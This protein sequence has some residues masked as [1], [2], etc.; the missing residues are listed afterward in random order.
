MDDGIVAFI[1][2]RKPFSKEAY[3]GFR[4]VLVREFSEIWV[5]DLGG[6]VRDNPKLSGTKHNVFG[7][8]TGVAIALCVKKRGG[9]QAVIRYA[10]RPET[11]TKEEKLAF[12]A[13]VTSLKEI[14]F[15]TVKPDSKHNWL[16]QT[17]NDWSE[18]P[19]II[20][21]TTGSTT[22][23]AQERSIFALA[24][25]GVETKRDDWAYDFSREG[26]KSKIEFLIAGYEQKRKRVASKNESPIKWDRE[27]D[28][29]M[30]RD[31]KKRF[32]ST[33][34]RPAA[35]R[36]YSYRFLYYDRHINAFHFQTGAVFPDEQPHP[37]I[38]FTDPFAQ[39]PWMVLATSVIP[40]RHF[41]GAAA[42]AICAGRKR[43]S[44]DGA[45][46][47]N[48]T[49]WAL[50]RF[51]TEYDKNKKPE[52]PITKN[53]IFHY[54]YGVLHDPV[55]REKYALNL[56][57]EFPRIP[58]YADFWKWV[59]WGEK[60]MAL[61]IGYETA[62]PWKLTRVETIDKTAKKSSVVPKTILKAFKEIGTIALDS[63]TQLTGVPKEAWDYSLGSR[64][65]LEWILDQHKEKTLKDPTV[66]EKFDTYRFADH[67]E[68]VIDLL[69]RVTR[70]SVETMEI[71]EAMKKEKR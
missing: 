8:Q 55:Y 70:V 35:Y 42:A 29:H 21:A 10:R 49:D 22:S 39:K 71:V 26:L 14:K 59:G 64:S 57:R 62:K 65:A 12:L 63:D 47:D 46:L 58:L 40:D 16:G 32:D 44:N 1:T 43:Y 68:K 17:S 52:R 54:V 66:R 13:S 3:D 61:H 37:C 38:V 20:S 45:S 7:I 31:I 24:T 6:D 69:M 56:K 9:S 18:L 51:R 67:K 15:E 4:K 33:L 36:P 50:E 25:N 28:K 60:L 11:E 53:A 5:I 41:V 19:A 34:I 2:G 27:L 23:R 30:R 48:V